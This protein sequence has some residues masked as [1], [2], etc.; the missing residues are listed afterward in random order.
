MKDLQT[1]SIW[2]HL[3]G[4]G[5]RGPLTGTRMEIVPLV[6][7]TWEQWRSLHPDTL[8][9][10]EDTRWKRNYRSRQIG[11]S[12]LGGAF[13]RSLEN[14]DG[15]LPEATLVLGVEADGIYVDLRP[16]RLEGPRLRRQRP[17][18]GPGHSRL[19][20]RRR[21]VGIGLLQAG[22]WPSP[23]L[24]CVRGRRLHR[25]DDWVNVESPGTGDG[26]P[27]GR[28]AASLHNVIHHR[29]VRLGGAPPGNGDLRLRDGDG[30]DRAWKHRAR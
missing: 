24:P 2:S 29:V 26:R 17:R 21:I 30:I 14:W 6:H 13:V 25:R 28:D 3:E 22:R 27:A 16:R 23:G 18:S 20:H 8:V 10:S 11:R 12:G 9:L 19:A 7:A 15:R 5:L 4:V 1:G